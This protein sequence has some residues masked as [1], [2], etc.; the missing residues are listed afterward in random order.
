M[1]ENIILSRLIKLTHNVVKKCNRL[2]IRKI[3][4][5]GGFT[6]GLVAFVLVPVLGIFMK[7]KDEKAAK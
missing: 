7:S 1:I 2:L 4:Y 6:S 5:N 3:L